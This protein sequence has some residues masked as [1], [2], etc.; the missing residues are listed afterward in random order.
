MVT[1]VETIDGWLVTVGLSQ[2]LFYPNAGLYCHGASLCCRELDNPLIYNVESTLR[3]CLLFGRY[4]GKR[5]EEE[6]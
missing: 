6:L 3:L 4:D 1:V 5:K 2:S